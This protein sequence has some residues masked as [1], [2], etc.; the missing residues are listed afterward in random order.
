MSANRQTRSFASTHSSRPMSL[1]EDVLD[2]LRIVLEY[3]G[4][5]PEMLLPVWA[6]PLCGQ[7]RSIV[8]MIGSN[9]PL[10][11]TPR[12]Y[13]QIPLLNSRPHGSS[14]VTMETPAIPS[15]ADVLNHL[16]LKKQKA[17]VGRDVRKHPSRGS[18][19]FGMKTEQEALQKITTLEGE[20]LKLRAQIDMMIAGLPES[21]SPNI[22]PP[23]LPVSALTSTPR[24]APP[25]PP[26]CP[27][28]YANTSSVVELIRQRKCQGK[29]QDKP[30]GLTTSSLPSM[31][32]ILKDLNQVK[33]RS[34]ARSPG[35]TPLRPRQSKRRAATINDPAGLIA[36]ALK[37]KFAHHR[38]NNSSDKENSLEFSPCNS[39]EMRKV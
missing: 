11:P 10:K 27:S 39:P 24:C 4:V 32:D 25:P 8:R 15:F 34:V 6:S 17:A 35:G 7:Y 28:S 18:G 22:M 37:R 36:E 2:V 3:F 1:L 9:L 12:V 23:V 5:P 19:R 21:R 29:K 31:L 14:D 33:L 38:H 30:T 20:L 16:P 13:I 26:P